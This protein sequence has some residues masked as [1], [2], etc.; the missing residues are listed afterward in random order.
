MTVHC[1]EEGVLRVRR[2]LKKANYRRNMQ[3]PI[4]AQKNSPI[5]VLLVRHHHEKVQDKGR[6]ITAGALR[7]ARYWI[8]HVGAKSFT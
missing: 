3:N 8:I 7:A 4:I 2:R 6:N 5:V 1:D